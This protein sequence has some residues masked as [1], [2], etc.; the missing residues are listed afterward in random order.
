VALPGGGHEGNESFPVQ[1]AL[2]ETFEET[3]IEIATVEVM[4]LMQ[5]FDTISNYRIVPVVGVID[6]RP[7][8]FRPCPR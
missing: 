5:C 1:T 2:R 4:G 7:S 3:G 6:E 8:A